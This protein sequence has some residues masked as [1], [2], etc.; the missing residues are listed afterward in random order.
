MRTDIIEFLE[1]EILK[2]CQS[3]SNVFGFDIYY[4][5]RA[6]AKNA[7]QL[8][9]I[10]GADPEIVIISAWLHDIAS[11]T[12]DSLY[13]E[14]H[15]HGQYI[16]DEI[17]QSLS[18]DKERIE[19]VKEC[20]YHHR[21]SRFLEKESPEEKCLADADASSHFDNFPSL[22][23]MAYITKKMG[24]QEGLD[25]VQKKLERSWNKLSEIGKTVNLSKYKE[26]MNVIERCQCITVPSYQ[27]NDGD[28]SYSDK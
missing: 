27:F 20:I 13:E 18:Y 8:A 24:L 12:E 9:E 6:V 10:Y 23:Y 17:L 5:I 11:I 14:H 7:S 28:R 15:I 25:F 2:R 21:G 3:K 16:A 26:T 19:R 22:L 1:N 4:H